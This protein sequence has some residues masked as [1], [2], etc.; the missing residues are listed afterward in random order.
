VDYFPTV[1]GFQLLPAMDL[2]R[3]ARVVDGNHDGTATVDLGA[4]ECRGQ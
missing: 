1:P 2:D 3:N 4:Y